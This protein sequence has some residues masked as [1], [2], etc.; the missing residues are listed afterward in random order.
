MDFNFYII[1]F[2]AD[3]FLKF[4]LKKM[5]IDFLLGLPDAKRDPVVL[6]R[7]AQSDNGREFTGCCC[8]N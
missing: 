2:K 5:T 3:G 8:S 4:P 1:S 7:Q 6:R